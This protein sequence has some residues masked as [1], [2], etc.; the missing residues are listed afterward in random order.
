MTGVRITVEGRDA[1]LAELG[2]LA[3]RIQHPRGMYDLIGEAL[4][5]STQQRFEEGRSPN[6]SPW[7]PSIRALAE[8]GQTLVKSARLQT[9]ITHAA[10]DQGVEVGTNVLYAAVHQF[11][12]TIRPVS[13]DALR[14]QIGDRW[15]TTKQVRIPARPFIGLDDDDEREIVA[16]AEDWLRDETAGAQP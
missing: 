1:A 16:I 5:R 12:A 7:P 4:V 2:R 9:S 3:A 10:S 6:G 13:A 15:V 11:G 8:G 14:F